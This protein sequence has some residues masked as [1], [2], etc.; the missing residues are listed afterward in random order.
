MD[1]PDYVGTN[2]NQTQPKLRN[3]QN[4]NSS[5]VASSPAGAN[6]PNTSTA[7]S[8]D[9]SPNPNKNSRRPKSKANFFLKMMI[10]KQYS[11]LII[12]SR[13]CTEAAAFASMAAYSYR[14][15]CSTVILRCRCYFR[16]AGRRSSLL[17]K[18]GMVISSS[19]LF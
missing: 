10:Y 13:Y 5:D 16:R 1:Q 12:L 18:F 7:N 19:S 2:V 8:S 11:N 17:L 15:N 4:R 6:Q 14:Q 3:V 9:S